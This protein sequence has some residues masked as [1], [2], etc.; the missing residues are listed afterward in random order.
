MN[1]TD[2]IKNKLR[3]ILLFLMVTLILSCS[4]SSPSGRRSNQKN[5]QEYKDKTKTENPERSPKKSDNIKKTGQNNNVDKTKNNL[6]LNQLYEAY[7][8]SVFLIY[9]TDGEKEYQGSGFFITDKGLAIS[10]YHVFEG[11]SKGLEIIK[12]YNDKQYSVQKV[13]EKSKKYD[14]IIFKVDLRNEFILNPIQINN[15]KIQIGE[16]VFAI[17]NPQGLESTL[18]KGIISSLRDNK[19]IIQTTTEI[20]NGSSG[21]PLFNMK[22]KVIGITTSGFG[23]ANLNFAINIDL[24]NLDRFIYSKK[25][26]RS[27]SYE[28]YEIKKFVDGDTFW[29][30]DGSEKGLKVRLIGIDTP[31]TVHPRKPV[32]YYGR[33]ASNFVKNLLHN[34][35]VRL[36]FDVDKKDRYGRLLAYVYLKNGTFLNETLVKR[37]YAKVSTVPPNVKYA[38]HFKKLERF[39]RENEMGLWEK[40]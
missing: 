13:L 30:D 29:I 1:N 39:A 27:S 28:F 15:S 6:T 10:N 19:K 21:G 35:K 14:Y 25:K 4:G 9:T 8:K 37:G 22:G 32:E 34:K 40:Q 20:T 31:E 17:G 12:T 7:K 5:K 23:E 38:D 24:L 18:S 33:E 26:G 36:E 16:D 2:I 3:Q 11:T